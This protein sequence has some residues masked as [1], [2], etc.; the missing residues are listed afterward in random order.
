MANADPGEEPSL[1]PIEDD[2]GVLERTLLRDLGELP[3]EA[4]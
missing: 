1:A 2:E 3:V 4:T